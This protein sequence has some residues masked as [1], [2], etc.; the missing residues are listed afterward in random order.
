MT[1]DQ[2]ERKVQYATDRLDRRFMTGKLSQAE[3]D[4][5]I[6]VLDKWA[7]QQARYVDAIQ[8]DWRD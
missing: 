5:E 4:H 7:C 6:M 8:V 1:E 2:I 3:Y